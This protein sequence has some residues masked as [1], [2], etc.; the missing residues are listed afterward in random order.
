MNRTSCWRHFQFTIAMCFAMGCSSQAPPTS[1]PSGSGYGGGYGYGAID[2]ASIKFNDSVKSQSTSESDLTNLTF[3]DKEGKEVPLKG[4]LGNK[5]LIL[6]ITRGYGGAICPYCAT[7]T[8]RLI[9]NYGK[10]QEQNAEVVVVYP[11]AAPADAPQVDQFVA[12]AVQSLPE[13]SKK[14]PFPLLLDVELK[15][16]DALGIRKDLSKPAT[17]IFDKDGQLR[18]AY[19]GES[20]ADRPSVQALLDQLVQLNRPAS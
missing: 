13:A 17:Y 11:L 4:L 18:F 1:S 9:S 20:L 19:V 16:V 12:K 2:D 8:S 6:V 15:A 7:Q 14:V 5:H 3:T 10:L